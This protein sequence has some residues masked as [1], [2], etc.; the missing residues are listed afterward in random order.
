MVSALWAGLWSRVGHIVMSLAAVGA[1]LFAAYRKGGRDA[2]AK[3][4]EDR[5]RAA[6]KAKEIEHEVDGLDGSAV[7]KRLG[8][9]MRDSAKRK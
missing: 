3:Q 9:W 4:T 6:N 1:I 7:D 5:I 8:K 2:G